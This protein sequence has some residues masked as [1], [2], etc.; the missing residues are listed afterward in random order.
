MRVNGSGS[1]VTYPTVTVGAE[2]LTVKVSLLAELII[3]RT[4][5]TFNQLINALLLQNNKDPKNTAFVFELW[6][7]C[8]SDNYADAG[9]PVPTPDQWA[10][11]IDKIT[12]GWEHSTPLFTEIYKA[13]ADAVLNR[14][15]HLRKAAPVEAAKTQDEPLP[16]ENP[17]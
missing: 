15:P 8:V 5:F 17:N 16:S 10:M 6:A 11:K 12:G 1:P 3:S 13:L 9:Q 14:W 7:A 2:V 4:G